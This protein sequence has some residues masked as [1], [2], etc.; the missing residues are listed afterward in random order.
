LYLDV[1]KLD[2]GLHMG[3]ACEVVDGT[4]DV[5]G[6]AGDGIWGGVGLLLGHLVASLTH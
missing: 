5:R 6:D 3:C 4:G 1:L 2:N